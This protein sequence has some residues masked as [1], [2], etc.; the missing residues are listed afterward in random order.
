GSKQ[1]EFLQRI[2]ANTDRMGALLDQIVQMTTVGDQPT[3]PA[4]TIVYVPEVLETAVSA[5]IAQIREK[6]L[7]LDMDI[8]PEL[9]PIPVS[10]NALNQIITGLLGNACQATDHK[11]RVAI[12]AHT[13][14]LTDK[15]ANGHSKDIGFLQ[16]VITDSGGGIDAADRPHVFAPRHR[17]ENPLI[18]GLGDTGVGLSV[19]R[20]L[21]EANGGRIWVD[22]DMGIGSAFSTL[23]PIAEEPLEITRLEE[24]H[25]T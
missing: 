12:S 15:R 4:N 7:Y 2:R 8:G 21:V 5:V 19:A 14:N 13:H 22:S 6:K 23:F 10:R 1:R 18:V 11:G 17:A 24:D 20:T 9:P 16:I 3:I 25:E